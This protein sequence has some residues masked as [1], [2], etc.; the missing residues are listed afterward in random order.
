MRNAKRSYFT[1]SLVS[2][3][4]LAAGGVLCIA[5]ANAATPSGSVPSE[6]RDYPYCE[7]IPD[8][9]A[10]GVTTEHVFNTLGFNT[11]PSDAWSTITE[12]NIV[13]AYNAA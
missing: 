13:D 3:G 9:V 2:L 5:P 1:R 11:C 7:I 4:A 10:N 12:Q 8:T 6:V